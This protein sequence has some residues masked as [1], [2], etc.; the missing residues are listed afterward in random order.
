VE[1]LSNIKVTKVAK[2]KPKKVNFWFE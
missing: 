2:K 1:L